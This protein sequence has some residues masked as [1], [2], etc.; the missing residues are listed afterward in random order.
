[1]SESNIPS[2]YK[3]FFLYI[4]PIFPLQALI[5]PPFLPGG[6]LE[7]PTL[8]TQGIMVQLANQVALTRH[9]YGLFAMNEYL[10]LSSTNSL[11]TW[12]RLLFVLLVV[13]FGHL[14]SME[15]LFRVGDWNAMVWGSVGFVL[16]GASM[17]MSFL[18]GLGLQENG[19][20]S[21]KTE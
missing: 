12:R 21:S 1:M 4:E 3:L 8:T 15:L 7:P 20:R 11:K 6:I 16:A 17:R 18:A 13:D 9:L 10:V 2:I 5:M 19:V 14:Y